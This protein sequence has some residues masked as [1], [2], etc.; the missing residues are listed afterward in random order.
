MSELY[1]MG[2]TGR[3]SN[4]WKELVREWK[5]RRWDVSVGEL[6]PKQIQA[7]CIVVPVRNGML[8]LHFSLQHS[9]NLCTSLD[10]PLKAS[11]WMVHPTLNPKHLTFLFCFFVVAGTIQSVLVCHSC[12]LEAISRTY[13][14]FALHCLLESWPLLMIILSRY[15]SSRHLYSCC[16][17]ILCCTVPRLHVEFGFAFLWHL[18]P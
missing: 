17:Q 2:V 14:H 12:K 18:L 3:W 5:G 7:C 8:L 10:S 11:V 9:L 6:L 4:L 1:P 13:A 16:G 15:D